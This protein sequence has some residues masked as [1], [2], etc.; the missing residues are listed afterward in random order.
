LRSIPKDVINEPEKKKTLPFDKEAVFMSNKISRRS[1]L[2]V[3]GA[4]AL[5]LGAASM[6]GGCQSSSSNSVE[7]KVGDKISNWN[8]LAVQL[9]SVF[10][11]ADAPDVPGSKYVAILVTAVNRSKTDTMAIGA[12]NVLEIDAAYPLNTAEL[13]AANTAPYFHAL[14][15]STTDFAVTVDGQTAEAGAY[16]ALYDSAT[17]TFNDSPN[18]PPQGSGYIELVCMV[19]ADW[20]QMT[21]TYTPTFV[22]GKTL[23]FSMSASDLSNS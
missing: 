20:Q 6:L 14:S 18:L 10:T 4:S 19:P 13:K 15:A 8:N 7:V 11:L 12:Q 23:T 3:S 5:A 21:V 2:K 1:F 22:S 16:V 9:T 17:E